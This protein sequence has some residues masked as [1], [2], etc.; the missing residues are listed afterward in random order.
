MRSSAVLFASMLLMNAIALSQKL[1]PR[2]DKDGV[3]FPGFGVE[4][5]KLLHGVSAVYPSDPQVSTIKHVC[6]LSAMIGTDGNPENIQVEN[7]RSSPL[8]EAAIAALRQSTFSPGKVH[9]Q[10]VSVR[11]EIWVPFSGEGRP[12]S[13]LTSRDQLDHSPVPR[14]HP[15]AEFSKEARKKRVQGEVGVSVLVRE[16]GSVSDMYLTTAQLPAGL[17]E[18]ALNAVSKYK[19]QPAT[20]DGEP[21]PVRIPVAVNFKLNN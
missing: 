5:P 9:G 10:P 21:V 13:L 3:Y 2:P 1:E 19:F 20:M 15:E 18:Q 8:D 4:S 6:A 14:I 17:D 16:D 11:I 7:A 12:A